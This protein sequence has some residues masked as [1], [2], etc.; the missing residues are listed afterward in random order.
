MIEIPYELRLAL[1]TIVNSETRSNYENQELIF[2]TSFGEN[3]LRECIRGLWVVGFIE[4][5]GD[6]FK[7]TYELSSFGR[8]LLDRLLDTMFIVSTKGEKEVRSE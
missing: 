5:D 3:S 2:I 4:K 8:R 1:E 6:D 7:K